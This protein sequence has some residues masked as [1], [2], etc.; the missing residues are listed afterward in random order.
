VELK[1]ILSEDLTPVVE[2]SRVCWYPQTDS[3]HFLDFF[4]TSLATPWSQA[5]VKVM[6]L[7]QGER[8]LSSF[9]L[10]TLDFRI[11][12]R[13]W[14]TAGI[15]SLVTMPEY[16]GKGHATHMLKAIISALRTNYQIAM[17]FSEIE[18]L[19]FVQLG[20]VHLPTVQYEYDTGGAREATVT[21]YPAGLIRQAM[22]TDLE[23]VMPLHADVA[24]AFTFA[25][26]RDIW[27]WRHRM[28][29]SRLLERTLGLPRGTYRLM[30]YGEP[31]NVQAY[32]WLHCDDAQWTV[33]EVVGTSGPPL[34]HLMEWALAQARDRGVPRLVCQVRGQ[35]QPAWGNPLA[36]SRGEYAL[37]M[38]PLASAIDLDALDRAESNLIWRTDRF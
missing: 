9:K 7:S 34:Q 38:H 26:Q 25:G 8:I 13:V 10:H 21:P 3:A 23:E 27:F 33:E 19:F 2:Q 17:A 20:F 14:R 6:G 30:V 12:D 32:M 24:P 4:R 31:G 18:P 15:G 22:E 36:T 11:G 1:E 16:R 37:M 28:E 35:A 5:H 29:L